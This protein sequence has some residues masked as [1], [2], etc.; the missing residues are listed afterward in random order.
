MD[1]QNSCAVV[2]V[3]CF[4]FLPFV[5]LFVLIVVPSSHETHP[6]FSGDECPWNSPR[7]L[8]H[9]PDTNRQMAAQI[10]ELFEALLLSRSPEDL[11]DKVLPFLFFSFL[12]FADTVPKSG[13]E[14]LNREV[15]AFV[16]TGS[17]VQFLFA[18]F[19]FKSP[20]PQKTTSIAADMAEHLAFVKLAQF[21]Q[22]RSLSLISD[23]GTR[24]KDL[25]W[26]DRQRRWRSCMS[27]ASFSTFF[28]MDVSTLIC[29]W[30]LKKTSRST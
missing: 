6:L 14:N 13:R 11:F 15:Q 16:E 25:T 17:P 12:F 30:Y 2:F 29:C 9:P 27:L 21:S 23:H 18:G 1:V 7:N 19:P 26:L 22:V 5:L 4:L 28:L 3:F 24:N 8:V 10:V 20:S